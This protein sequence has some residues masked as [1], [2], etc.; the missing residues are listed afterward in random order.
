[1]SSKNVRILAV[2]IPTLERLLRLP[3]SVSIERVHTEM[4][5]DVLYLRIADPSFSPVA[6]SN[7]IPHIRASLV[8]SPDGGVTFG[9]WDE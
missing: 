9:G 3:E 5:R 7:V 2:S 8:E 4:D 6:E 1:V